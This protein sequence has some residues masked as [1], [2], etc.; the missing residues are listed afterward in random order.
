MGR[1]SKLGKSFGG[2]LLGAQFG[3]LLENIGD[4]FKGAEEGYG[5][6]IE[7]QERMF[8]IARGDLAPYREFGAGALPRLNALSEDPSQ[9]T[10]TPGYQFRLNQGLDTLQNSAAA[11][12][13]LLSGN[14]LRAITDYGQNY[15]SDEY[16]KEFARRFGLANMG[17]GAA[18]GSANLAGTFGKSIADLYGAQGQA[19]TDRYGNLLDFGAGIFG[20]LAGMG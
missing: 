9:I 13:G 15:A 20:S 2:G 19:K 11:R 7:S 14:A 5:K 17:L 3:G 8:N 4:G 10:Q 16:Q 18:G 1:L 12:G 6:G